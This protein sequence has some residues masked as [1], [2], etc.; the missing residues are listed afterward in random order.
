MSSRARFRDRLEGARLVHLDARI[1]AYHLLAEAQYADLT[2]LL[3][4]G[5]ESGDVAGQTSA[6]TLYQLLVEPYRQGRMEAANRAADY[7][8]AFRNLELVPVDPELATQAAQVRARLG[9]RVERALQIA[10]ALD[11][12]ADVYLTEDSGLRRVAGMEIV[13]LEDYLAPA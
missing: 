13:S 5:L 8:S 9:G 4:R 10:T 1:V 7:L 3:F 12:E 6:V 11:R 2:G